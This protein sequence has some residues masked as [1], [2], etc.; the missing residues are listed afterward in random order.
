[1]YPKIGFTNIIK[2]SKKYG[3]L[4]ISDSVHMVYR[5]MALYFDQH[6]NHAID[7]L[8]PKKILKKGRSYTQK[9]LNTYVIHIARIIA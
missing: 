7:I 4:V 8:Y 9:Q 5:G 2:K 1:M 6:R 3:V